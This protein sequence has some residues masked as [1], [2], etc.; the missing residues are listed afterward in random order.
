[1]YGSS[2]DRWKLD[3]TLRWKW[4]IDILESTIMEKI[5]QFRDVPRSDGIS[6]D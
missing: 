4:K 5:G 1:M 6:W 2:Y 3:M